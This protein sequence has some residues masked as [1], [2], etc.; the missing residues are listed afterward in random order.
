MK[1][2]TEEFLI[3]TKGNCDIIDITVN[4]RTLLKESKLSQGNCT[5]FVV[6]STA[7]ISTIEY[8]PGLLKDIPEVLEQI[9]PTYKKYFH[10][11]TW[12]DGN[13]HSHVRSFIIKTS[14]TIPFKNGEL[15]GIL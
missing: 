14:L 12:G 3:E 13:G 7:G 15:C 5:A 10:N 2:L 1:I 11:E 8:E 4:L 9:A 6:G